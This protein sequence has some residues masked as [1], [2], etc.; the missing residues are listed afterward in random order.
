MSLELFIGG[1]YLRP[2]K[3]AG[4]LSLT[5]LSVTGVC[6]GVMTLIVVIA[7]ITG[8]KE[9]IKERLLSVTPHIVVRRHLSNISD[10]HQ[11]LETIVNT[12]GVKGAS[13][14]V[15]CQALLRSASNT[16]GSVVQGVDVGTVN[17]VIAFLEAAL[18]TRYDTS[19][20]E[21]SRT[22]GIILGKGTGRGTES[23]GR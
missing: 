11:V 7:V 6:L 15:P 16:S 4:L 20:R 3:K 19:D 9:T 21:T 17:Q 8:Y 12:P 5:F 22:E 23:P 18:L 10:Y 1:R 2:G 13:P 14:I